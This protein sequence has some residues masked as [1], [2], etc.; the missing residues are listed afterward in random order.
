MALDAKDWEDIL[1][2]VDP[3]RTSGCIFKVNDLLLAKGS[4]WLLPNLSVYGRV[5]ADVKGHDIPH[6]L[7]NISRVLRKCPPWG[8]TIH[9]SGGA[10]MIAKAVKIFEGTSTKILA[11]TVLTSI[12]PNTCEEIYHRQPIEQVRTLGEIARKAG[13]HG[14][15]CSPEETAELRAKY[16]DATIVN[17]GI[18]SEGQ[19]A[20]DQKRIS[21]PAGAI[22][23]GA[24][25]LVMGRQILGAPDPVA[26]VMRVLRD[27][28]NV[29]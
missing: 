29:I 15:V 23:S 27:E 7:E 14:L 1:P 22:A 19:D 28:L 11:V 9:A 13:A 17:P 24:S 8:V 26:E 2:L 10:E 12:D 25:N 5:M 21:T 6:T 18:R 16:P 20:G 3:L 4:D